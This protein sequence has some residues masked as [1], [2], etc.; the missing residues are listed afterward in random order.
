MK[1]FSEV[2]APLKRACCMVIG[3]AG[4]ALFGLSSAQAGN[5]ATVSIMGTVYS[6][7]TCAINTNAG[8][9]LE[10]AF[11]DGDALLT[12]LIDGENY[13]KAIP[14]SL[15][16]N[17][18][19]AGLRFKFSGAGS[20]FD[21]NS[22]ATNMPDLGVKLIKPDSNQV[23]LNQSFDMGY[24]ATPTIFAVPVKRTN[25]VLPTG[26]FGASAI[27]TMEVI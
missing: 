3:V 25:A 17:G 6:K 12:T 10:V 24:S 5:T 21:G 4:C 23:T 7:P 2:T 16:C 19:P 20:S 13:K 22:L 18:T 27:L 15:T 9:Y 11:G 14:L 26:S 1:R 8:G